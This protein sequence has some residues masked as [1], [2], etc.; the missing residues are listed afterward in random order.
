M[1][2]AVILFL[3]SQFLVPLA[4]PHLSFP[5]VQCPVGFYSEKLKEKNF[6]CTEHSKGSFT[7]F[8]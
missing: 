2:P 3:G 5:P 7:M 8:S 1:D 6:I 4:H